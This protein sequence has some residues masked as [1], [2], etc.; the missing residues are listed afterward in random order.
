[1]GCLLYLLCSNKKKPFLASV[2]YKYVLTWH[3]IDFVTL[4]VSSPVVL[5]FLI[6]IYTV[7]SCGVGVGTYINIG[8]LIRSR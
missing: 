1:M 8:T 6:S 2:H 5:G 3:I 7:L 4:G